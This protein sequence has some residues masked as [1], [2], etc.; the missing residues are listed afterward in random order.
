MIR[1][2]MAMGFVVVL[3]SFGACDSG[4][5]A[6]TETDTVE[7]ADTSIEATDTTVAVEQDTVPSVDTTPV[8]DDYP[9][10]PYGGDYLDIA[11]PDLSF[12]DPWADSDIYLRDY[13]GNP[14]IKVILISSAAGWC[15]ACMYEAWDLVETYDTY[16]PKGLEIIYTLFE[17][18]DG[19]PMWEDAHRRASD[20]ALMNDWHDNAGIY[21]GL[22]KRVINYPLFVDIGYKLGE[23][24]DKEATPFTIMVR[25]SD[26]R[27]VY[28]A[29]GYGAGSIS[30]NVKTVLFAN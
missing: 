9:P 10:G 3:A 24:Y 13:Y 20:M 14:D 11:D 27:I 6:T 29:V 21:I 15:T 8:V 19:L 26:M 23:Y 17:D 1:R 28:R 5:G 16:Q 18:V 25:T 4:G 22:P 2:A 12:Y 30:D 7:A